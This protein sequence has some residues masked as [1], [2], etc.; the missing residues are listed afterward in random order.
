MNDTVLASPDE[1]MCRRIEH[2]VLVVLAFVLP[3]FEAP[4]N[5]LW[6]VFVAIWLL[7][8]WRSRDFG[9]RW[10]HWDTLIA[11]WI[12]SGFAVAAFAGIHGDEWHA[13]LDIV[14]Y[15]TVL[16]MLKRS[17]YADTIWAA[18]ISA[19]L[20]GTI[21]GLAWGYYGVLVTK[22]N[23]WLTLNSVGHVNHSSIYL[24][25]V[26][27]VA[28]SAT[29]AWWRD[30]SAL[31]RTASIAL[32]AFLVVALF[33]MQSRAAVGAAFIM[34]VALLTAYAGRRRGG[35]GLVALVTAGAVVATLLVS[36]LVVH[37]NR[38]FIEN[39]D[40]LNGRGEIWRLGLA[41]WREFPLFGVGMGNFGRIDY[42]RL[43]SWSAKRGEIFEK[44]SFLP[45][46][47][48]HS[49]YVTTLAERGLVGLGA[50]LA[51]LAAWA[52]ALVRRIPGASAPPL[53]WTFWGSAAGAWI[54]TVAVG[55]LNTTLHHEHAL[56]CML[57]FGGWLSLSGPPRQPQGK[58]A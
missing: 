22:E 57:L 38:R 43:E 21:V 11:L 33:W 17:R 30:L 28:L 36:P 54:I 42:E 3:L 40:A 37:K 53:V 25:I 18:L 19:I 49:L 46:A 51:V 23:Y 9:G 24:A 41:A 35:L 29:R 1:A 13:A 32:L 7:N 8:R 14:R 16:W 10:D 4:K 39:S 2:G 12:G 34:A 31:R 26:L 45:A 6:V 58:A 47:H 52:L 56:L 48:G 15:A 27:G 44:Q 55:V 5:I 20:A 50:V